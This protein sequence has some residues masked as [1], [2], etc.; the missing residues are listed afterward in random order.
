MEDQ[1][2]A[3]TPPDEPRA[4]LTKTAEEID[5]DNFNAKYDLHMRGVDPDLPAES[6][7]E[8][9][10]GGQGE[11]EKS[12]EDLER[13]QDP[14][15]DQSVDHPGAGMT[16]ADAADEVRRA[17]LPPDVLKGKSEDQIL[18]LGQDLSTKR[19]QRDREHSER[20]NRESSEGNSAEAPEDSSKA[21]AGAEGED[22]GNPDAKDEEDLAK[23]ELDLGEDAA[24]LVI[25]QRRELRELKSRLEQ[26]EVERQ[27]TVMR[28]LTDRELDGLGTQFPALSNPESREKVI[29]RA[30]KLGQV[31]E[32]KYM[33]LPEG[34]RLPAILKDAALLEFGAPQVAP[35]PHRVAEPATATA[36]QVQSAPGTPR[37]HFD[38]TFDKNYAKYFGR[39]G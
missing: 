4:V 20:Q 18:A 5:L 16:L 3:E 6:A 1:N 34:E 33:G 7:P 36:T 19:R 26:S 12:Q 13:E 39:R 32:G 25:E 14:A 21:L 27:A 24:R 38:S 37:E 28:Q 35:A 29:E 2:Q 31:D 22:E 15:Q 10:E 30:V 17:G 9:Q 8:G 11:Q 23:L